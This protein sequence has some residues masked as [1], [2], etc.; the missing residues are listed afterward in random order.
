MKRRTANRPQSPR[1]EILAGVREVYRELE[2]NPPER[3]CLS[4][5]DCCHFLLT[6]K[7]PYLTKGEALLLAQT[8]KSNGKTRIPEKTGGSCPLLDP[9]S[10]RCTVY[11]GRPFGCRTHFCRAAGGPI[12]RR[13]I[14]HLI[15]R[16]EEID[17]ACGGDGPHKLEAA[18]A[19]A[20]QNP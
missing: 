19:Q 17:A 14:L 13:E 2:E 18:L 6:G 8:L 20:L 12:A 7:T 16:L 15:R 10:R 5:A 11:D 1:Q 4:R 3:N 9:Q